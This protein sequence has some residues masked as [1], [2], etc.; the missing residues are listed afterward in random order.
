MNDV[1]PRVAVL[2]ALIAGL[3]LFTNEEAYAQSDGT[4]PVRIA[5]VDSAESRIDYFGSA[6]AHDWRGTSHRLSGRV[7]ID[8]ATPAASRVTLSVPVATFDSGNS[9]RDRKMRET[10]NVEQFPSVRFRTDS[11]RVEA[12]GR[13]SD[14][15]AGRWTVHGPLT[16]YGRT[17]P[18]EATVRVRVTDDSLTAG[19]SFPVSLTRFEVDR[20]TLLFVPIADT[21]RIE[22][23]VQAA[24][25]SDSTRAAPGN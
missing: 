23:H 2:L 18:I 25:V 17:H 10:L 19:T 9:R 13:T 5:V 20:P 3:V 22:A 8:P 12:W 16:F 1:S 15:Q 11:V 21:I 24:V 6:V 14:G 4:S 7:L